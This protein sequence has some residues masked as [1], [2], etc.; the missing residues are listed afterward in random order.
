MIY[1]R[2]LHEAPNNIVL[3]NAL[4]DTDYEIEVFG[5]LQCTDTAI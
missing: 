5:V 1:K 2:S 3:N 4:V